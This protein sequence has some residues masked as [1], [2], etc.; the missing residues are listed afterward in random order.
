MTKNVSFELDKNIIYLTYSREEYD[1]SSIDHVLYRRAYKRIT[2]EEM[3][4]I[5]V[6]LDLYKL[7]EMPV[8]KSSFKN[9]SYHIKKLIMK[10]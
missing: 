1:R 8:H 2:D 7:Y 3:K 9:N 5:Y 6:N 4:A 10:V